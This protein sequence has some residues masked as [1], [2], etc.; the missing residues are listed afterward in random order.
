MF[1]ECLF[2]SL[3]FA[4]IMH[5]SSGRLYSEEEGGAIRDINHFRDQQAQEPQ[6]QNIDADYSEPM[7]A[8][9]L[10]LLGKGFYS[11][12]LDFR[13]NQL[14][15]WSVG[16]QY[17]ER[18]FIPSFMYYRFSGKKYRY[19]LGG[20]LSAIFVGSDWGIMIHGVFGYRYQKKK[21]LIFRIGFTPLIGIPFTSEGRFM[22]VPLVGMSLGYSL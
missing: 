2:L 9:Y 20:G 16:V 17:I 6:P 10:E 5:F 3:F 22:I 21:G 7:T 14:R 13:R 12:N 15:A 19:E 8:F 1:R 4:G 18:V 11:F